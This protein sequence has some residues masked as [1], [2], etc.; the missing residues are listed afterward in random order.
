MNEKTPKHGITGGFCIEKN[1]VVR[2]L[3]HIKGKK[4]VK[5]E[6]YSDKTTKKDE[7]YRDVMIYRLDQSDIELYEPIQT[8]ANRVNRYFNYQLD[9]IEQ[10]QVMKYQSPSNGYDWHMDL[11]AEGVSLTRKIG[12]SVLLNED[13]KGG[14]LFFRGGNSEQSIKPKTGEVVAFSSFVHHKVNPVTKGKRLVLVFWLTG[15]CFR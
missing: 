12:V 3:D 6:I 11:G 4:G 13:Y 10:A 14:E 15:P 8:I 5:G 2:Y 1:E 9:G 7:K